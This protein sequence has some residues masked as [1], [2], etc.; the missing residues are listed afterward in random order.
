MGAFG[1]TTPDAARL[2]RGCVQKKLLRLVGS[3][4]PPF[5]GKALQ[6]W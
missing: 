4:I 3:G 2:E 6:N 1:G 5:A